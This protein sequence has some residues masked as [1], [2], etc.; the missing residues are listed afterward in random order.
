M[1]KKKP[2]KRKPRRLSGRV[3]RRVIVR[4][5]VSVDTFAIGIGV[6]K[7]SIYRWK[8]MA[9]PKARPQAVELIYALDAKTDA[10]LRAL[11]KAI[12]DVPPMEAARYVLDAVAAPQAEPSAMS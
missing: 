2:N 6:H 12:V 4:M 11:G 3:I 1:T 10:E 7:S 5:D 9:R 8:D